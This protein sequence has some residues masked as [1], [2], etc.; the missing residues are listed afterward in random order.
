MPTLYERYVPSGA[1]S[2]SDGRSAVAKDRDR[3]VHS[4]A[5]RRLQRKS[6]IVGAQASDFFRT[7]LTHTLE[8]AQI[9]RAIARRVPAADW[10]SCVDG[11]RDLED[12]VE[13]VCLAHDL[14]HPPFGHNGE[15]TLRTLMRERA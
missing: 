13:A 14:G 6:Q 4:G 10:Q 9:G 3:V 7:R 2:A 15:E 12:L 5:L 1:R 8:C 11:F